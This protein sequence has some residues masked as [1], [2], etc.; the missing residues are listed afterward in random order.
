VGLPDGSELLRDEVTGREYEKLG[1]EL[2]NK[3]LRRG[4]KSILLRA[5][6]MAFGN[7]L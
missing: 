3:L 7:Q 6:E 4:A 1:V 2:A 5:E